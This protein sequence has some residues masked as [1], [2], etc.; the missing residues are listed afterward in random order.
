M[1]EVVFKQV[2]YPHS[3]QI[4]HMAENLHV[5]FHTVSVWFQN[6]RARF[7]REGK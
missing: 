1:L 6:R 7:K 5:S 3:D 2:H 4:E